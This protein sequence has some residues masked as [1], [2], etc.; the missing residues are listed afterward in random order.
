M[1]NSE[2]KYWR[3]IEELEAN[4]ATLENISNEFSDKLPME[5]IL[6]DTEELSSNRRDFLK[7]FGFSVSAVALAACNKTPV[8]YAMPYINKPEEVTPGQA[9]YYAT[10]CGVY[11]EGFPV[12]A[13]VREGRPIKL[14]GNPEQSIKSRCSQCSRSSKYLSLYDYESIATSDCRWF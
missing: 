10:T 5:E 7:F 6:G 2:N 3:G 1:S 12:M 11:N 9:L 14:D 4:P 8:K 13:K